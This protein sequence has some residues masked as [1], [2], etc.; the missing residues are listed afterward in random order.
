MTLLRWSEWCGEDARGDWM[1]GIDGEDK[2][3]RPA[4]AKNATAEGGASDADGE[5]SIM[6]TAPDEQESQASGGDVTGP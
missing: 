3:R 5:K 2:P 1:V 6:E 4:S